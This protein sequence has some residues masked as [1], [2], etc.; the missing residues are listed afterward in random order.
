MRVITKKHGL[1]VYKMIVCAIVCFDNCCVCLQKSLEPNAAVVPGGSQPAIVILKQL[2]RGDKIF[3][4]PTMTLWFHQ[5][6]GV[7]I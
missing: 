6:N 4:I 3:F 5:M 1:F 2:S 7:S